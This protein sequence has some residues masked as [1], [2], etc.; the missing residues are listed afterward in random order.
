MM[1]RNHSHADNQLEDN[2]QHMTILSQIFQTSLILQVRY[3]DDPL[4]NLYFHG[5]FHLVFI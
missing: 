3:D 1:T 2:I 4:K 5:V